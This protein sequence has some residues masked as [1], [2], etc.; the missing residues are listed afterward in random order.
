VQGRSQEE[1]S[2]HGWR[3]RSG[4]GWGVEGDGGVAGEAQGGARTGQCATFTGMLP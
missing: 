2:S 3:G 1:S 4:A